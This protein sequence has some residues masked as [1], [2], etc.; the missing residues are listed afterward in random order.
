VLS[1]VFFPWFPIEPAF[2]RRCGLTLFSFYIQLGA[3][4]IET[5]FG[6]RKSLSIFTFLTGLATLAFSLVE[7]KGG[8]ILS[9][10]LISVSGTAMCSSSICSPFAQSCDKADSNSPSDPR[11]TDSV[12]YGLTPETFPTSIRGTA[13][14]TASAISRLFVLPF[15]PL[16]FSADD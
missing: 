2:S 4:L 6:R 10:C 7:T 13:C 15:R 14:G 12:L 8:V 16:P 11:F 5:S 9:S 3:L 1:S